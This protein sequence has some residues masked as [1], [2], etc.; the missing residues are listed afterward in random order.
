M[1]PSQ[2][3][4]ALVAAGFVISGIVIAAA[5]LP[6]WLT[7]WGL[8]RLPFEP[9]RAVWLCIVLAPL[10][11]IRFDAWQQ[12]DN[13]IAPY[14]GE[15]M[16]VTGRSDGRYLTVHT[17]SD[18]RGVSVALSPQGSVALGDAVLEGVWLEPAGKRNPGG[19]DYAMF[20]R[21]RNVLGQFLV[22]EVIADGERVGFVGRL[23]Q[24][25][26]VGVT[27]GLRPEAAAL[28]TAMTL[29]IR[30][31]LGDLQDSFAKAGLA[32]I[33]ALS[34][35]HVGILMTA[36]GWALSSV[37]MWRYP[38]L[39]GLLLG[40]MALV[41]LSPS[42]VRAGL[43]G[44]AV[45]VSLWLGAGRVHPWQALGIAATLTLLVFPAWVFDLSFQLSYLAVAGI[46]LLTEPILERI[47]KGATL[48]LQQA[49]NWRNPSTWPLRALIYGSVSVSIAAQALAVPLLLHHF[50]RLPL[51]A[52]FVNVLAI[53]LATLLVPLGFAAGLVGLIL[54]PLAWLINVITQPLA[55]LL[56][57]IATTTGNLPQLYWG[58]I[59]PI[60]FIYY[61]VG[62]LGLTLALRSALRWW[63][64]LLLV[65]VA[66]V[67]SMVT[68]PAQRPPE[69]VYLDVGQ[70]DSV[71]IRLPNR[72][73]ILVDGGGSPFSDFDVGQNIVVPALRAMGVD[74]LELVIA[75]HA[76]TDHIEGLS[77]VLAEIPTQQL[78]LG[79]DATG[80]PVYDTLLRS[81][82]RHRVDTRHV[83]RGEHISLGDARLD[84]LSPPV[85]P[86]ANDNDNSLVFVL[87]YQ[88]Q[89]KAL[90]LGDVST[91][92]EAQLAFPDVD[93]VM[94]GHHGSSTSTSAALLAAT[95]PQTAVISYGRNSFGHP[96]PDVIARLHAV[97]TH[98]YETYRDGAVRVPLE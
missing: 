7:L 15:T 69:I 95:S 55:S 33:L 20:L 30:S 53:P 45:L 14:I 58:E 27:R 60:G 70:G 50:G 17:P 81:A 16:Q 59:L 8:V 36:L 48:E 37:G 92:V 82:R 85:I 6:F 63:R 39:I 13:P 5:S 93:I 9:R 1:A 62:A 49:R 32:H 44:T 43:M 46:L 10:G 11:F 23:K 31:E 89:P 71:L 54:P 35:L 86:Y 3:P 64:G 68:A 75:S 65:C 76:D 61:T 22:Q 38:L 96:H 2:L 19:F 84:F 21:R 91:N 87:S 77:S 88:E 73:E 57:F 94:V 24:R 40:F 18:L 12:R 51:F 67:C 4:V 47:R 80:D 26:H 52:P 90:F 72:T 83:R 56:M 78:I 97:G 28:M 34:G 74:E 66:I 98:I 25:L 42:I 29:G 79:V 41:G